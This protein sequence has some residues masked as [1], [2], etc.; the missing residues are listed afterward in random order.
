M[1]EKPGQK[2]RVHAYDHTMRALALLAILLPPPAAPAYTPAPADKVPGYH[3]EV[4]PCK[5]VT[6]EGP[7]KVVCKGDL[8]ERKTLRELSILRNTIYARYGWDGYRKPWL[9]EHF[10]GQPWFRA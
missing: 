1:R 3:A 6:D 4:M 7:Q 10:H 5:I 2:R 9:R 8:L